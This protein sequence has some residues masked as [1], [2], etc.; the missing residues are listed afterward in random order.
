MEVTFIPNVHEKD[1]NIYSDEIVEYFIEK[2]RKGKNIVIFFE[3]IMADEISY[4]F[5]NDP[6]KVINSGDFINDLQFKYHLW[7]E[8]KKLK[9]GKLKFVA[10]PTMEHYT[11]FLLEL[12]KLRRKYDFNNITEILYIIRDIENNKETE[13]TIMIKENNKR[14]DELVKSIKENLLKN[15]KSAIMETREFLTIKSISKYKKKKKEELFLVFGKAH[16][17]LKWNRRQELVKFSDWKGHDVFVNINPFDY[18][19]ESLI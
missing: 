11:P 7:N 4:I 12:E 3:A 9:T 1:W 18:V 2:L 13:E 17:F 8:Y 5:E 16:D 14:Y 19:I 6:D 15:G 10:V